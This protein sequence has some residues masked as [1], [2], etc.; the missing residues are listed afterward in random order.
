MDWPTHER[1]KIRCPTNKNDFTV[2]YFRITPSMAMYDKSETS[3]VLKAACC[4]V[5]AIYHFSYTVILV[6]WMQIVH[7]YNVMI[8]RQNPR[9]VKAH[10]WLDQKIK[11]I[12]TVTYSGTKTCVLAASA[13]SFWSFCCITLQ[14]RA[15]EVT[16]PHRNT[17]CL[18]VTLHT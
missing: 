16:W 2:L 6:S 15:R 11:L 12:I 8:K 5:L 17:S 9:N 3:N 7:S 1:H 4:Q 14:G 13:S 10:A 18:S